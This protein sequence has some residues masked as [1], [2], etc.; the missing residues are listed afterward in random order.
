MKKEIEKRE[1]IICVRCG[2]EFP[3]EEIVY[4]K[5]ASC[6]AVYEV[7]MCKNCNEK[8]KK[9]VSFPSCNC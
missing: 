7:A 4:Q 1:K 2:K 5:V 6:C 3:K 9:E 8:Y